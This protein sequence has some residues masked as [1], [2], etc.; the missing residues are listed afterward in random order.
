[1]GGKNFRDREIEI[2]DTV[3]VITILASS[4]KLVIVILTLLKFQVR[5]SLQNKSRSE[6]KKRPPQ[7]N[8]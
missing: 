1:M 4:E 6:S 8:C 3:M 5:A 2:A 7:S